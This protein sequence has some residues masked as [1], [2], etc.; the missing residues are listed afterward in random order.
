MALVD[1]GG[2]RHQLDG[3]DAN[4]LEMVDHHRLGQGRDRAAHGGRHLWV[5]QREGADLGLVDE[6]AGWEVHRLRHPRR[7]QVGDDRL[8]HEGRGVEGRI[9]RGRKAGVVGKGRIER[10]G[11]GIDQELRRIEP[12]PGIRVVRTIGTQAIARSG[13]DPRN[14]GTEDTVVAP[15]K[16][17]PR[18]FLRAVEETDPHPLRRPGPDGKAGSGRIR[19]CAE[20]A[21]GARADHGRVPVR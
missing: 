13:T 21:V 6:P 7:R 20:A 16:L 14:D 9:A 2:D 8:G 19:D 18:G 12:Q 1:P 11:K 3:I 10:E 15:S 17:D 5:A 4:A